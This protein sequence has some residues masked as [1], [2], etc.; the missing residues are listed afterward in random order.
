MDL[1]YQEKK[2][3]HGL[4]HDFVQSR[5]HVDCEVWSIEHMEWYG[6]VPRSN[7]EDLAKRFDLEVV[8][9]RARDMQWGY[10]DE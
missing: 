4:L 8:G 10:L 5:D 7:V 1:T 9:E 3:L 6:A 2:I